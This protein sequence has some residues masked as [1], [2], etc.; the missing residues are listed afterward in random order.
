MS[1]LGRTGALCALLLDGPA[2]TLQSSSGLLNDLWEFDTITMVWSDLARVMFGDSVTPR[3]W[4]GFAAEAG[5][6]YV[7]G[8]LGEGSC[9]H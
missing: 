2:L 6:L 8:G 3:A 1:G 7:F 4:F 5:N 9:R